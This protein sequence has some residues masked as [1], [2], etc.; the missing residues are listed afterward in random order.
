MIYFKIINEV[1]LILNNLSVSFEILKKII[2]S[3]ICIGTR[4]DSYHQI[5]HI[6][7]LNILQFSRQRRDID[8]CRKF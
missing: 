3:N 6:N 4:N 8:A 5:L 2:S 7:P 1:A